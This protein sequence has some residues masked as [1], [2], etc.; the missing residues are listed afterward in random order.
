MST[1]LSNPSRRNAVMTLGAGSLLGAFPLL[2]RGA[3]LLPKKGRRVVVIGGGFA[4]SIAARTLRETD[5][6]IEVVLVERDKIY[7][8][9]PTSNLVIAGSRRIEQNQISLERLQ[10]AFGVQL[11]YGE[12][13][14]IDT[15]GKNVTLTQGNLA[16][17]KL[18]VA[19]GIDFRFSDI[20]GYDPQTTPQKLPHAWKAGAQ[21]L[22][23]RQQ[24]E[25]M[26]DGG[27]VLMS[28]PEAPFRAPPGPYERICQIAWYLK[29]A[30]PKSK[31]V[32]LDANADIVA[33]PALFRTVWE[34]NYAGLIDYRNKQKVVRVS[35]DQ[36][37]LHT[38]SAS[39]QGNV[40][41]L[42]PPQ[43]AGQIAH[44][45]GLVGDDKA[46][47]PVNQ[48]TYEST[49]VKDVHVVGDACIAGAMLKTGYSANSQAKVCALNLV[50]T[51]NGKKPW[52][53][54]LANAIYSFTSDK[55]AASMITMYRVV[56]GKT[57]VVPD[58][59][60]VAAAPS[61]L[62]G[63]YGLAWISNILAEMSGGGGAI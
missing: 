28:I 61:V 56:D 7:T 9:C 57:V 34:K 6:S 59:G 41:N 15:A 10:S 42:I 35:P 21:T 43:Q 39:F 1:N 30:K 55:E 17:D 25:S 49:R 5:P 40:V 54:S 24:L 29:R 38:D 62:E 60:G 27:S 44:L 63:A 47:C 14:A 48:V 19:P 3:E 58:T 26:P 31:L 33:K 36:M 8:A 20:A 52:E 45:A 18:I 11:V 53:P 4:G 2:G 37:T 13:T 51:M 16:Y 23:L 50:A 32:V 46:W 22:L 12:V